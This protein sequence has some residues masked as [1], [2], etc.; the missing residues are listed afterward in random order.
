MTSDFVTQDRTTKE[1]DMVK[2]SNVNVLSKK[3]KREMH[4][5]L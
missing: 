5:R 3:T 2:I 1:A 4:K